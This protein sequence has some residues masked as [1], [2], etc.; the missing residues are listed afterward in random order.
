MRTRTMHFQS[1]D[2]RLASGAAECEKEKLEQRAAGV[3]TPK[4]RRARQVRP[5]Y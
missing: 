3:P 4:R 2:K 5:R 1:R